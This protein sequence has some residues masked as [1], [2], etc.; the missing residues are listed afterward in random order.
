M[1]LIHS[2]FFH[3]ILNVPKRTGNFYE[4]R[5]LKMETYD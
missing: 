3:G 5:N 1:K 2:L 4:G